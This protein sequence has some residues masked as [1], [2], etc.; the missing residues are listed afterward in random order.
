MLQIAEKKWNA[1]P[2][3]SPPERFAPFKLAP[4]VFYNNALE[5]AASAMEMSAIAAHN[6]ALLVKQHLFG[7][8]ERGPLLTKNAAAAAA[9]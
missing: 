7:G 4:G 6:S 3:F 5:N 2:K 1:Y 8:G 9:A